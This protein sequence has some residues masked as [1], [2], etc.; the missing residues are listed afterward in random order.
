[1]KAA[2]AKAKGQRAEREVARLYRHYK[3]DEQAT[4]MPMSGAM[5]FHKGDILK[6]NDYQYLDEVK[7]QERVKLWEWWEQAKAQATHNRVPVLHI[8]A[9]HR[10]ILTVLA[11]EDYMQLRKEI[12]DLREAINVLDKQKATAEPLEAVGG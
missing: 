9:N 8:T 3:I 12:N 2:S 5:A 6:P 4:R 10:P 1:V 11:V 7:N